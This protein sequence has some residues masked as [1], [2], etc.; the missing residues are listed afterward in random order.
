MKGKTVRSRVACGM[1]GAISSLLNQYGLGARLCRDLRAR[2]RLAAYHDGLP[3]PVPY[4][5]ALVLV[6]SGVVVLS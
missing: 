3:C 1:A 2:G 5:S 6:S 4:L